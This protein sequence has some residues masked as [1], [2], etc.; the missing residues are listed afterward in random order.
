MKRIVYNLEKKYYTLKSGWNKLKKNR[1]APDKE[2]SIVLQDKELEFK[3]IKQDNKIIK[4]L[5]DRRFDS[6]KEELDYPK[7]EIDEKAFNYFIEQDKNGG[8]VRDTLKK[9]HINTM[10]N[11]SKVLNT[12]HKISHSSFSTLVY[13]EKEFQKKLDIFPDIFVSTS[14]GDKIVD[15]LSLYKNNL[16]VNSF[17]DEGLLLSRIL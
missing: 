5:L 14:I 9:H 7:S 16:Q 13:K 17:K 11:V 1:Y 4:Q 2:K 12:L 15:G 6:E 8:V 3:Y 10:S